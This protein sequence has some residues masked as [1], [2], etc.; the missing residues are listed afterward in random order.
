MNSSDNLF[1]NVIIMMTIV[2]TVLLLAIVPSTIFPFVYIGLLTSVMFGFERV[3]FGRL[4]NAIDNML[5][6][7]VVRICNFITLADNA[8]WN[9]TSKTLGIIANIMEY[10]AYPFEWSE[11]QLARVFGMMP[12]KEREAEMIYM[13]VNSESSFNPL[14]TIKW[15]VIIYISIILSTLVYRVV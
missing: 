6:N 9:I 1:V 15:A 13:I 5:Y 10:I 2:S 7:S 3:G 11:R 4:G 12:R 14:D 8:T